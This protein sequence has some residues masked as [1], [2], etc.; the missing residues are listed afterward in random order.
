M[1]QKDVKV[2]SSWL[3]IAAKSASIAEFEE[4]VGLVQLQ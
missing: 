4:A 1:E 3:K 2:L